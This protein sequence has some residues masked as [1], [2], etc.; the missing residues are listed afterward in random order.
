[1]QTF[2]P[3]TSYMERRFAD[4]FTRYSPDI[5][6][7]PQYQ[8]GPFYADFAHLESKTLIEIDG[9]AYHSSPEQLERDQRRQAYLEDAGWCVIRYSGR[10]VYH[11]PV[12]VVY[13]AKGIIGRRSERVNPQAKQ[14]TNSRR[15]KRKG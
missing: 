13:Q 9:A 5:H 10:E 3:P 8:I 15:S 14:P 12:R 4:F 11:A 7:E 1:M 2:N 6:L